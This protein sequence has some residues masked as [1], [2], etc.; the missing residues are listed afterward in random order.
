MDKVLQ[1]IKLEEKRQRETLMLIPSENY[2]SRDVRS[3]VGSVLMNKY[4][5]GYP[6]RRYYQG[7]EF[8]DQIE[9]L[10]IERAK[11]LFGAEHANVQSYS[12]SPANMAVYHALLKPGDKILGMR[13]DMGGHLTHGHTVNF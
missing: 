9:N 2:T 10:A 3:A 12:G 13:L 4:S 6:E 8:V 11:R 7:N 5:E 1:L